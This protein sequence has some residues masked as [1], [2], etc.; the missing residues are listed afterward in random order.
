ML[1]NI[2]VKRTRTQNKFNPTEETKMK[3]IETIAKKMIETGSTEYRTAKYTYR[4]KDRIDENGDG[5]YSLECTENWHL[6]AFPD[7]SW[8]SLMRV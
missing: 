5:Y 3:R 8:E 4:I 7:N 6:E 1:Y 2:R